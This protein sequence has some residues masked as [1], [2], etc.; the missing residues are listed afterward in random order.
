MRMIEFD[1]TLQLQARSFTLKKKSQKQG[2]VDP[3]FQAYERQLIE[4][5][6]KNP[7]KTKV[8]EALWERLGEN[9]ANEYKVNHNY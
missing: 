8:K 3:F 4:Q 7:K 6:P 5:K 2:N 9:L 1:A